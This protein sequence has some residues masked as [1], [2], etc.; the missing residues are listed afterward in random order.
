MC[1]KTKKHYALVSVLPAHSL[2]RNFSNLL[3]PAGTPACA[4]RL[5]PQCVASSCLSFDACWGVR[6]RLLYTKHP[7]QQNML[8]AQVVKPDPL[9]DKIELWV[10]M[11]SIIY[12]SVWIV[13]AA[14]E[15]D[16]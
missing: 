13:V 4:M 7:E 2:Q 14:A 15:H 10:I 8:R 5:Q 3:Q 12:C 6:H 16:D 9:S 11:R 1:D